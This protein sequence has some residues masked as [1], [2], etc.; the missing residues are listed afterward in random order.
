MTRHATVVLVLLLFVMI[1]TASACLSAVIY[2]K[3]D[4]NDANDGLSWNTA[5]KTIGAGLD[6]AL[7][8]D[9]VW[10]AKGTYV[11]RITLKVGVGLYGGFEGT[12]TSRDQRNWRTN[13]TIIDGITK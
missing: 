13:V 10:V 8:G 11:E 9:E 7:S 1:L 4:G 12:E 2:V 6:T 3:P 5:K